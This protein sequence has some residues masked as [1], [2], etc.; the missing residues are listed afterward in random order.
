M[1]I[2]SLVHYEKRVLEGNFEPNRGVRKVTVNTAQQ[3][4]VIT[5]KRNFISTVKLN[6]IIF[7]GN[8]TLRN[9]SMVNTF[10]IFNENFEMIWYI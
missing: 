4:M 5:L 10:Y 2:S 8:S 9:K 7:E 6:L 3:I 1:N